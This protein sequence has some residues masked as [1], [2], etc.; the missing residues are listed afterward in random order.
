MVG[1]NSD[2]ILPSD[3]MKPD[4]LREKKYLD[5]LVHSIVLILLAVIFSRIL[6]IE[7]KTILVSLFAG[8]FFPDLDH[9]LLYRK[10]KFKNFKSFVRWAVRSSRIRIGLEVF[11]NFPVFIFLSLLLPFLWFKNIL[12]FLFFIGFYFHL[13]VDIILDRMALK[14]LKQWRFTS[15]I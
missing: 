2:L 6:E 7:N 3:F 11:H 4:A 5:T 9:L 10:E 12:L 15:K 13:A 1:I 8:T 14:N